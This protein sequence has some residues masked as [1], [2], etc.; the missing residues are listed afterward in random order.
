VLIIMS[1][2]NEF[3]QVAV[4][5]LRMCIKLKTVLLFLQDILVCSV[6]LSLSVDVSFLWRASVHNFG[7]FT[8]S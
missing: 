7:M 1:C 4:K 8:A 2:L 5:K 6:P 3:S